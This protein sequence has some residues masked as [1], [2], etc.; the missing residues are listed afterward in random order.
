[1]ENLG[2][3]S[4]RIEIR[5]VSDLDPF[6][7]DLNPVWPDPD[8]AETGY[9]SVSAGSITRLRFKRQEPGSVQALPPR[10]RPYVIPCMYLTP[11]HQP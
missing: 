1:M 3:G 9:G 8:P 10:P 4:Y 7:P 11:H 5:P 2:S 6:Y